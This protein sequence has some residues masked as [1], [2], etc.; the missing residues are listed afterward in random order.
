MHYRQH[1]SA[2]ILFLFLA[3]GLVW[4]SIDG[5]ISGVVTDPSGAVISGAQVVAVNTQTGV[6]TS[7]ATDSK[8]FY[9][10]Q[11]L[12][13]GTYNLEITQIGFTSYR[14]TGLVVSRCP[15]TDWLPEFSPPSTARSLMPGVSV[16]VAV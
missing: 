4:A 10:F 9:N 11:A 12:P 2:A 5:S 16:S 15:F 7:L 3:S 13:V 6:R 8:G 1:A 14:K